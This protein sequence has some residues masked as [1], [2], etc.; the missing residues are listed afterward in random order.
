MSAL[1]RH[2]LR[3]RQQRFADVP[4]DPVICS[5]TILSASRS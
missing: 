3:T 1:F 2:G 5:I 4:L